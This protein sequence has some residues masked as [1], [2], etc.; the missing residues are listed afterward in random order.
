VRPGADLAAE[1]RS[2]QAQLVALERQ[3]AKLR[4][5]R[6]E[7][8]A[9]LARYVDFYDFSPVAYFTLSQN[10]AIREANLTAANYLGVPRASLI[11]LRLGTFLTQDTQL[12]FQEMHD[13]A[14]DGR[15]KQICEA[16]LSDARSRWRHVRIEAVALVI[17]QACRV[18]VMDIS[19][20]KRAEDAL[21]EANRRKDEFLAMLG[22]ELR[23]PLAP[24][25]NAAEV[26]AL[27]S[28]RNEE[29]DWVQRTLEAQVSHIA[30]LVDDLLDVSRIAK[31][32]IVLRKQPIELAEVVGQALASARPLVDA[33]GL[34][35]AVD[36]PA[37]PVWLDVDPVR[38]AQ[39]LLNL[40]DNA[41]KFSPPNAQVALEARVE[42]SEVAIRVRDHGPGIAADL[43]PEV[44][45]L[46]R[47]GPQTLG[48]P[49]GGLGIGLYLVSQLSRLHGGRVT[50]ESGGAGA[51]AAFTVWLPVRPPPAAAAPA[52]AASRRRARPLRILLVDDDRLVAYSTRKM[53]ELQGH[54]VV[55]A[56]TGPEALAVLDGFGP[57]VV[58]LDI[59]LE[60]MD[61]Y[62]TCQRLRGQPA[63]RSVLVVGVSGYGDEQSIRRALES[64]FDRYL[65]KPV[66]PAE[67][68]ALLATLGTAA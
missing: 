67:L 60:G 21:L 36:L 28:L 49:H 29:I 48:R 11:G 30:R 31:G 3:N 22:H 47:Q 56:P 8:E 46:F 10:G 43:L 33:G 62:E 57:E 14:L 19:D 45:E 4:Q 54:T 37:E 5:S 27:Q 2:L 63:G 59:G 65:V 38:V 9:A 40:L 13:R 25:R 15:G 55:N 52:P 1:V 12:V 61:G 26:L 64:G 51:G 66:P 39:A 35:L 41:A 32:K 17:G 58:L 44:F 6:K 24:I 7:Q 68:D 34:H 50:A 53:L 42:G 20:R 18:V 16:T 23:N